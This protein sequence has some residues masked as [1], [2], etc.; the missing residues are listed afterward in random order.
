MKIQELAIIFIIII[1]PIT[2]VLSVYTQLQIK[3][4]EMQTAY[5]TKLTSATVDALKAFQINTS[6][7]T[8]SDIS[9]SKIRDLEASIKTFKGSLKSTFG[10]NGYTEEEMNQYIPNESIYTSTSIHNV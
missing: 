6:N 2:I 1:L 3:T 9:N 10:L 8:I 5:D 4:V 7:S